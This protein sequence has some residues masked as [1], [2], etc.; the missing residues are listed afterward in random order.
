MD[1]LDYPWRRVAFK[2]DLHRF[3]LIRAGF[4][5]HFNP[6]RELKYNQ[7]IVY[8]LASGDFC[9]HDVVKTGVWPF[10]LFPMSDH[11]PVTVQVH[12]RLNG[13]VHVT[14][15]ELEVELPN[16]HL[17]RELT[18]DRGKVE[19]FGYPVHFLFSPTPN[20]AGN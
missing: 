9:I 13:E 1:C 11:L 2:R 12:R 17:R 7:P 15:C 14:K 10:P 20:T 8:H 3:V 6:I 5:M 16:P 4:Q 19:F 18:D